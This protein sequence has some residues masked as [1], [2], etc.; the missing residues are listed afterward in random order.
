[1]IEERNETDRGPLSPRS[2]DVDDETLMTRVQRGDHAA[3]AMLV[4]RHQTGL[5]NF[6]VRRLKS[7]ASAEDVVQE[8]FVRVLRSSASFQPA[9]SFKAWIYAISRNLCIDVLRRSAPPI[10]SLDEPAAGARTNGSSLGERIPHG[11]PDAESVAL[12][13]EMGAHIARAIDALVDEQR[14]VFLLR[15]VS[16]L[17]FKEIALVVDVPENTVKSRMRYALG[18]LQSALS[19]FEELAR[20]LR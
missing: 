18:H 19:E 2:S 15:E 7:T 5:Y 10:R 12:A 6:A 11:A 14:E 4:R 1:V 8:A 20:A 3:F 13:S 17:S 16:N 9:A